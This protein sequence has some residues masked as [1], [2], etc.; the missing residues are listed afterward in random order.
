MHLER[1]QILPFLHKNQTP[2]ILGIVMHKVRHAPRLGARTP[3]MVEAQCESFLTASVQNESTTDD[4]NHFW[5]PDV[6]HNLDI[7]AK[8]AL[9][10]A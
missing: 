4:N 3:H 9:A 6:T 1:W 2:R 10:A 7:V 8:N 5:Q